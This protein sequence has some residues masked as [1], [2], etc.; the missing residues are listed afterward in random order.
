[1]T[2]L[3]FRAL[4]RLDGRTAT[5]I[6]VP[7]SVLGALEGGKRPAVSVTIKGHTFRT[8]VGSMG[9]RA[10]IPV[11]AAV[12]TQAGLAAGDS[13]TVTVERD[14]APRNVTVPADLAAAMSKAPA[15]RAAFDKLSYGVQRRHV[16]SVENAKTD[17]TRMR[18]VRK[19]VDELRTGS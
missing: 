15:T 17:E 2:A 5:G 11:S 14:Q 12:R 16:E 10:L 4:I 19:V 3:Q 13:V 9:G 6:E 8:S 18:R 1:M 7:A